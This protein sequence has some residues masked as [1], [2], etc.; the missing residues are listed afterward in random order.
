MTVRTPTVG[1]RPA[2]TALE[3]AERAN[4]FLITKLIETGESIIATE[5]LAW[6]AAVRKPTDDGDGDESGGAGKGDK[7]EASKGGGGSAP[8]NA[9]REAWAA[10]GGSRAG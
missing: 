3:D 7:G 5:R 1:R 6:L 8:D 9:R 4:T 2:R 10:D